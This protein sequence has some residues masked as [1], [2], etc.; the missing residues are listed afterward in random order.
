MAYTRNCKDCD[1]IFSSLSHAQRYCDPCRERRKQKKLQK[2]VR[3]VKKCKECMRDFKPH[4]HAVQYCPQC[5]IRQKRKPKEIVAKSLPEYVAIVTDGGRDI[6]DLL[7]KV[8]KD[9]L[10]TNYKGGRGQKRKKVDVTPDQML[11]AAKD[12]KEIIWGRPSVAK[13]PKQEQTFKPSFINV[14]D[15]TEGIG[16][17]NEEVDDG[18]T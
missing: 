1:E 12:L 16:V 8:M 6:I 11:K 14:G 13:A 4:H 3:K 5:R 18:K 2:G 10:Y 9:Q 17:I 7:V 15:S